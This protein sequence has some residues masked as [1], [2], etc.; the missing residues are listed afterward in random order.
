MIKRKYNIYNNRRVFYNQPEQEKMQSVRNTRFFTNNMPDLSEGEMKMSPDELVNNVEQITSSIITQF[1]STDM[2]AEDGIYLGTAGVA[3]MFYHLSKI[4]HF[5]KMKQNYLAS[6]VEYLRPALQLAARY[7]KKT[8][9]L[10][11]F[12][13]GNGGV[14]AVSSAIFHAAQDQNASQM[15][16]DKYLKI[17]SIC[18]SSFLDCGEDELFVGRAGYLCGAIWLAKETNTAL[19]LNDLYDI[20]NA[21]VASGRNYSKQN[22]SKSPLMFAYY[23]KEYLGAA[24]GLCS[25]LQM[26]MCVPGYLDA[27]PEEA[28]SIKGSVDFLLSL[29]QSNGNFPT[30]EVIQMFNISLLRN[31]ATLETENMS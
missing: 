18:K 11:S 20:C 23:K 16:R 8:K 4:P 30:Q 26:L 7:E 25:I 9:H 15:Y 6:A 21:I 28:T 31:K 27:F 12:I 24:H 3:Y 2:N 10:P 22:E 13:L 5:R 17:A 1:S 19:A 14:Y 29:Q